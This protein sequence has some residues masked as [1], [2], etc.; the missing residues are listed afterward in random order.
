MLVLCSCLVHPCTL[1]Y[2]GP[3]RVP[4]WPS[5]CAVVLSCCRA[6][7]LSCCRA[8]VLSCCRAVVLSCCRAA[9]LSCC[10]AVVLPC[11]RAAVLLCC[12][13]LMMPRS[14]TPTTPA[15][16]LSEPDIQ[17]SAKPAADPG[18][19]VRQ[20]QCN[21]RGTVDRFRRVHEL[22]FGRLRGDSGQEGRAD[23]VQSRAHSVEG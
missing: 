5:P 19:A 12:R 11:C 23:V 4:G 14:L 1:K 15:C 7:V 6:V 22:G 10:R 16:S 8:V 13:S 3:V 20:R 9:V 17:V 2:P 21:D 18:V